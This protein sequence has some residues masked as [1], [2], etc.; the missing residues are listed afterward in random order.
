[1]LTLEQFL[2]SDERSLWV[3]FPGFK[4]L[5]VRQGPYHIRTVTISEFRDSIQLANFAVTKDGKGTFRKLIDFL[6]ENYPKFVIVVE[7]AQ[8]KRLNDVCRHMG[9]EQINDEYFHPIGEHFS[10]L[11]FCKGL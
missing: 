8:T 5:Y 2:E 6:E 7:Q 9:F 10:G 11:H 4:D 1:M 3:K